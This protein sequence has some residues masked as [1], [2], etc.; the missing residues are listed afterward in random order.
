MINPDGVIIGNY[1]TSYS[2]NDLNRKYQ[3]PDEKLHPTVTTMK[4]LVSSIVNGTS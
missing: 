3:T 2:G 1:R 4:N